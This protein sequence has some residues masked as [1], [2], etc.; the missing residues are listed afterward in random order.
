MFFVVREIIPRNH[1]T[2]LVEAFRKHAYFVE[3]GKAYRTFD[4]L[5]LIFFSEFVHFF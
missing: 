5:K 1:G 4:I 2:D 3:I